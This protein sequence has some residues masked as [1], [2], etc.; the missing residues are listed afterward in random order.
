MVTLLWVF[1]FFGATIVPITTGIMISVVRKE[2]QATSSSL[3]QLIFNLGGY[4]LS[5]FLTGYI[6]DCFDDKRL[7]FIWGMRVVLWW[8]VFALLS[9]GSALII[10]YKKRGKLVETER[11]EGMNEDMEYF[12]RLEIRRRMALSSR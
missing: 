8:V 3:S 6:M 4:F 1:L 2:C 11:S 10:E 9:L 5:P 12:V 7:G